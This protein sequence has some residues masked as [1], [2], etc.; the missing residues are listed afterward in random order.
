MQVEDRVPDTLAPALRSIF[1]ELI[2]FVAACAG[3]TLAVSLLVSRAVE[4]PAR[5]ALRAALTRAR[6][7][8]PAL[9]ARAERALPSARP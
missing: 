1:D 8:A 5:R 2:P 6:G 3:A 4:R 7:S 9:P